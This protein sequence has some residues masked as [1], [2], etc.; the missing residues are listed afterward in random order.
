MSALMPAL[1]ES[2]VDFF[3]VGNYQLHDYYNTVR[4]M[5]NCMS[6]IANN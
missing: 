4:T 5:D 6:S 2:R 3:K 1:M